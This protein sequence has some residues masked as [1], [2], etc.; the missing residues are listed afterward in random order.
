MGVNRMKKL[1]VVILF[2]VLG[3]NLS[4][5]QD[6]NKGYKAYQTGDYAKA[7][8]EWKPMAEQGNAD[9]QYNLGV[10]L[11]RGDGVL[12]DVTE[13]VK[14]YRLSAEKGYASAQYN[15][16]VMYKRGDGVLK[17]FSEA[18]KWYRLSAEQ[19]NASA[20]RN[21]GVMYEFGNGVLQD[22]LTAHMWYNIASANGY[23][24]A[25][26]WRDGLEESMTPAAIEKATAMAR[27][28]MA[29]D[30]KKCGY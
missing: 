18:L 21:L 2:L 4:L 10:M 22:N 7:L 24:K 8:K 3:T 25:G 19:G 30:Y 14:W 27:E 16:G 1:L 9:A 12:K 11:E 28:C 26:E 29:S 6:Y 5:A 23:K 13:A 17:D 15:L 20:Q